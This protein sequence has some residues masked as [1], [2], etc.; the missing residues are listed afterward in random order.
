MKAS[1]SAWWSTEL[2]RSQYELRSRILSSVA[3]HRHGKALS[4]CCGSECTGNLKGTAP[5]MAN[6]NRYRDSIDPE[7]QRWGRTYSRFPGVTE[8]MRLIRSGKARG[9]WA[10]IISL[11]LAENAGECLAELI[12]TFHH[13]FERASS[14]VCDDGARHC[15]FA[16]VSPI[17]GGGVK[18]GKSS[19]Y[20]L[21]FACAQGHRYS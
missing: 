11:E 18:G 16:G 7:A 17:S 3:T 9:T 5:T 13:R 1:S 20:P 8:C 15:T 2:I 4:S 19:I 10:T 6:S 14:S 21:R 12:E